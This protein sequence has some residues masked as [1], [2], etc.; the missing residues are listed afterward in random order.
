M[1]I[2]ELVN[3]ITAI[4]FFAGYAY[5]FVYL[6]VAVLCRPR[7]SGEAPPHR[8]AILICARNEEGVVGQLIGSIKAQRYPGELLDV[9]LIADNCTDRT[10]EA[11]REA[12]ATV[13]ERHDTAHIGKGYALDALL[14]R[15]AEAG[16]TDYDGYLVFDADNI[17][18]P[19][20]MANINR[21]FSRGFDIVTGYRNSK[22]F[23][24]NW[25]SA[26][27]GLC[28]LRD[29]RLLNYPR[30]RLGLSAVVT[31]TGFLFSR[32]ILDRQGGGW[33][34]HL[35]SEDTQFS[36]DHILAGER[37]GMAYDAVFYDEQ[38]TSLRQSWH[39]RI[40]WT[41]GS[42]QV[43]RQ[44]GGRLLRGAL[45]GSFTCFDMLM[46]VFPVIFLTVITT[47]VGGVAAVAEGLLGG[48]T[49]ALCSVG[50]TLGMLALTM[51]FMGLAVMLCEW[52]RIHMSPWRKLTAILT[53]PFYM[54]TFIPI[55]IAALLSR[56]VTWRHIAHGAAPSSVPRE[57]DDFIGC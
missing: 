48:G 34:Y 19:D 10:A 22:N 4:L 45:R 13:W 47:L 40:R 2:V 7:H 55:A 20:F 11:A 16:Y 44:Y 50:S 25:I 26:G 23:G 56:R 18:A 43:L 31:G 51:L 30:A 27:Y 5:Q 6:A 24:D 8:F 3:T 49:R 17:L 9:F 54:L 15:M 12:G 36:I 52:R 53:F 35:L 39:Q 38:P 14:H 32:R 33:P 29:A 37:I 1:K 21:T 41:R 57:T 28:F 42:L 46:S